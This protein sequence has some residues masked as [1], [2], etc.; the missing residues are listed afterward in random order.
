MD[1]CCVA[2]N[3]LCIPLGSSHQFV[4]EFQDE[5]GAPKDV[6]GKSVVITISEQFGSPA[7]LYRDEMPVAGTSITITLTSDNIDQVGAGQRYYD[8]WL[9]DNTTYDKP[10]VTGLLEIKRLPGSA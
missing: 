7:S 8:I 3:N 1:S 6:T 10:L 2:Q 9:T 4:L 5:N